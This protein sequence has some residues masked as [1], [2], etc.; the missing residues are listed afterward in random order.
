MFDLWDQKAQRRNQEG[1]QKAKDHDRI[2]WTLNNQLEINIMKT[3]PAT[4]YRL[5]TSLH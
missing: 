2:K 5:R 1:T 3:K 4:E